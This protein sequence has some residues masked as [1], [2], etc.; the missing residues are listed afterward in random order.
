[1]QLWTHHPS[2]FQ[3]DAPDLVIDPT[4]GQYW[5]CQGP[6][7]RYRDVLPKLHQFVG[8]SQ[9]LWCCTVRGQFIRP[10]ED[11][12]LIEWELNVP[13]PQILRFYRA[14]VWEGIV[15]GKSADWNSLV[16][17][18]NP[19]AGVDTHA[20]VRIPL[21]PTWVKCHGELR[22]QI[23]REALE[24]ANKAL[25]SSHVEDQKLRQEYPDW[26]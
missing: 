9:F 22:P 8:T 21:K 18:G 25:Q 23:S 26:L 13:Q 3:I 20:L 17:A 15:R 5:R 19:P 16:I 14:S 24:R 7:F 12:D 6:D 4:K 2:G 10:T 1:V 11:T